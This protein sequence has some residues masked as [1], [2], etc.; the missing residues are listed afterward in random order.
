MM[1]V[2]KLRHELRL[3]ED[4]GLN[5]IERV[6]GIRSSLPAVTHIDFSTR[7]QT[8]NESSS[9]TLFRLLGKFKEATGCSVLINTSFNVRGEPIV[10][11][12]LD[13]VRCFMNTNMDAL[14]LGEFVLKKDGQI[15]PDRRM[16]EAPAL[17]NADEK[18]LNTPQTDADLK[19]F[20]RS[21]SCMVVIVFGLILPWMFGQDFPVWP[22]V[23]GFFLLVWGEFLPGTLQRFHYLWHKLGYLLSRITSPVLLG[24]VYFLVLTPVAIAKRQFGSSRF[25]TECEADLKTYREVCQS[26][27]HMEDPF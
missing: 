16:L 23:A 3:E 17:N 27:H 8:V 18:P 10:E 12:P 13:A 9:P 24:S 2:V 21:F 26:D 22:W 6:D 7:V 14:V 15:D 11:S 4:P 19:R 20:A 1:F 25:R 5:G